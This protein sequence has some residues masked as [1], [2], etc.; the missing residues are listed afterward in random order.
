MRRFASVAAICLGCSLIAAGLVY[1][2]GRGGGSWSTAG[3][4]AQ[5]TGFQHT[6]PR[7]TRDTVKNMKFLWKIKLGS[8]PV[9]EASEPLFAGHTITNAGFKDMVVVLGPGNTLTNVDYELGTILWQRSVAGALK[10]TAACPNSQLSQFI[11]QPAATFGGG[12]G[13]GRAAAGRGAPGARGAAPAVLGPPPNPAAT[14]PRVGGNLAS[15]V[16]FGGLRGIFVLTP[17]GNLHEQEL[18]NGWDY[19][20]PVKFM[21]PG[22]DLGAPAIEGTRI[23]ASAGGTCA[24]SGNGVYGLDMANDSYGKVSFDSGNIPVTGTDGPALSLD[25]NTLFVATGNGSGDAHANSV[26]ALDAKTMQVKDY[27]TPN[28]AAGKTDIDVS[29][30]VFSYK[31]SEVVAAFVAGGRLALLDGTSLGGSDHHT[32][33][34]ITPALSKDGG[35]GAWG[36]LASAEDSNGTRFVYVSVNGP[37]A[38]DA[39]LPTKNGVVTDGAIVA[40]KVEGDSGAPKL[41]PVWVSPNVANPSPASI[42]M[43]AAPPNVDNFG[44][45]VAEP[46]TTP[47]AVKTGGIVFTLAEGEPGKTNARLYG[48]DA[49]TGAQIYSSAE[50]IGSAAKHAGIAISGAHVVFLASD[51][52]L[53]SFGIAY[54]KN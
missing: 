8:Q 30:V 23:Y 38:T 11:V 16:G 34:A 29:P 7:L 15:G 17:D 26:L 20:D 28:G 40:F 14:T 9:T 25:N 10:V 50:E 13:R 21:L 41:T 5:L 33:L 27:F 43:T 47:P 24:G 53:Y 44:Q 48:F 2:Q 39:K 51:N 22:A 49:E 54:E 36:R 31:G 12:R 37:L 18:N 6:E 4:D 46:S 3:G 45:P 42:V 52:T 1:A 32:P 19:G 35:R